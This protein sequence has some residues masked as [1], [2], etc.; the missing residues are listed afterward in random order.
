M[1]TAN[2]L[3]QVLQKQ[4]LQAHCWDHSRID[5]AVEV[6]PS[7]LECRPVQGSFCGL[8]C[9]PHGSETTCSVHL[10]KDAWLSKPMRSIYAALVIAASICKF[11]QYGSILEPSESVLCCQ[12]AE[13]GCALGSSQ[14]G[15]L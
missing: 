13:E 8:L 10:S 11:S 7:K 9:L 12:F 1:A 15:V 4:A 3:V 6:Q 14:C 5:F 2:D